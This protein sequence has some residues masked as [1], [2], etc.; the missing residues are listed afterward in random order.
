MP[1]SRRQLADVAAIADQLL[2]LN[3]IYARVPGTAFGFS[4][5]GETILLGAH[6]VADVGSGQPV[7]AMT[8]A[9]RCA[10]I[11]KSFT[12]TIV[13]QLSER[14]RL[15]VD[16]PVASWLPWARSALDAG[17]TIRHLLMHSGSII[18][19]GSNAW[20]DRTMPDRRTLRAEV[21]AKASFGEP[22][23][24]FRYSNVAYS[25]LGEIVEAASGRTFEAL[26]N[27]NVVRRLGLATTWPDL[28]PAA[29][30]HLAT[31]YQAARP[32]EPRQAAAH[33]QA[34][35][36]APAGG[37]VST[38][39]DLLEYQLAHLPGDDRL[40]SEL[41]KRE[42]QRAQW[43]RTSEPHY[44]LG[45]MTWHVD[46]ISVVG[47]SGGFPGFVTKIGYAPKESIAAAVLTN[48]N[49]TSAA[50][51]LELIYQSIAGVRRLWPEAAANTTS[52]SRASLAP[53]VGLYRHR[54]TDLLVARVNGSLY[55]VDPLEPAPLSI[56]ARLEP[57]GPKRFL[58]A[59][60]YDFAFLGEDV[61]FDA[62]RK[63]N[64]TTLHYGAHVMTREDL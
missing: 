44:G 1:L 6:G 14:G 18:R 46:E 7:D 56:A 11:T 58:V 41:S 28:T 30:R 3:A 39:P 12:A 57:R 9:F 45:W 59:S 16:D 42:M 49:S 61:T 4:H 64:V 2:R 37:L 19:D 36:V 15:R 34:R 32:D 17:L 10:S 47:H 26:V 27:R 29:R 24:R 22:S 5:D 31:G 54:G 52:H 43:Q 33:V 20:D 21:L 25:L 48:A 63:G 53:F 55:L 38:V 50:R 40:L 60:G 23:E 13:M 51:G 35:A 8:T 62:D